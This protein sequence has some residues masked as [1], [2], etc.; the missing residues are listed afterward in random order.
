[1][2]GTRLFGL[3][4]EFLLGVSCCRWSGLLARRL[5]PSLSSRGHQA[6]GEYW[7]RFYGRN[8]AVGRTTA[9]GVCFW[10]RHRDTCVHPPRIS[11]G[12]GMM[13]LRL[14]PVPF[15]FGFSLGHGL[16][17]VTS[18]EME[19]VCISSASHRSGGWGTGSDVVAQSVRA[20]RDHRI[21]RRRV[22]RLTIDQPLNIVSLA[23]SAG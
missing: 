6:R 3:A 21:G 17:W 23:R 19:V 5:E 12:R 18:T 10:S 1:L 4:E 2:R 11:K 7:Q 14:A 13:P 15:R 22:R 8:A 20:V 16:P 9:E